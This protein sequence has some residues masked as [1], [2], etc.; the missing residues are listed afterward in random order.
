MTTADEALATVLRAT[1][2]GAPDARGAALC[3]CAEWCGTCREFRAIFDE[4]AAPIPP[5]RAHLERLLGALL[6]K[7]QR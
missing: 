7:A 3:L 1:L 6:P 5:Q 2:K 4:T